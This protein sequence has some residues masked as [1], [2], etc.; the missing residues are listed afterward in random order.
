M[1]YMPHTPGWVGDNDMPKWRR[2]VYREGYSFTSVEV[3][4]GEGWAS[5]DDYFRDVAGKPFVAY[6]DC[7]FRFPDPQIQPG[8]V[9]M[10][11]CRLHEPPRFLPSVPPIETF[12]DDCY[13]GRDVA[14]SIKYG[15]T[16]PDQTDNQP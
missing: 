12:I 13:C 5:Q 4:Q 9:A 16:P 10:V 8:C 6:V 3:I 15:A 7:E 11:G 2:F 14:R 1:T